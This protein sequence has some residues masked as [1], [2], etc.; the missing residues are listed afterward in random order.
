MI[1]KNPVLVTKDVADPVIRRNFENLKTYFTRQNQLVDFEFQEV[2]F[3][4]AE[5]NR[6][7][8]HALGY[9][10]RDVLVSRLTGTGTVTFNYSEFD[11]EF[12]DLSAS[13]PCQVRF[14]MGAKSVIG[15][16]LDEEL[17]QSYSAQVQAAASAAAS[18]A[19]SQ[20]RLSL[21]Y[22]NVASTAVNTVADTTVPFATPIFVS[23]P[24]AYN[25]LTGKLTVPRRMKL[26]I[27]AKME[28]GGVANTTSQAIIMKYKVTSSPEALKTAAHKI[29][30][31]YGNGVANEQL[32]SGVRTYWM[33]SGDT[34]EVQLYNSQAVN[35]SAVDGAN[36]VCFEELE[37]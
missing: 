10:P 24:L 21:K 12:V 9:A 2:T 7:I 34:V 30:E 19:T 5:P 29:D 18:E 8:R 11:D 20:T 27:S 22:Q 32:V 3:S 36:V 23:H 14:Y 35:L 4:G 26:Q 37:D 31:R 28:T 1:A 17:I 15:E 33:D 16:T 25:P 6:R 13:G